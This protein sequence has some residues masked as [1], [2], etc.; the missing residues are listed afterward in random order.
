M[1]TATILKKNFQNGHF[2]VD[3]QFTNGVETWPMNLNVVSENDLKRQVRNELNR[4]N[5]LEV[6]AEALPIGVYDPAETPVTPE[7]P[8]QIE[9]NAWV[10]NYNK[11]EQLTKLHNLGGLRPNIVADLDTLRATVAAD[12]KKAY[13]ADM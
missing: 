10:R 7:T 12:F 6:F 11:L 8:E 9:K 13:I 4:L 3:V 1:Y 5:A 2:K